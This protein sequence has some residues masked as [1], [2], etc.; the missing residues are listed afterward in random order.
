MRIA[1]T[2]ILATVIG[3]DTQDPVTPANADQTIAA[4]SAAFIPSP[5]GYDSQAVTMAT[6]GGGM[7]IAA[8]GGVLALTNDWA[9]P[10]LASGASYA[11]DSGRIACLI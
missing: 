8:G 4:Q 7:T 5:K 2:P 3:T 9:M 6:D 1:A 11:S 10:N